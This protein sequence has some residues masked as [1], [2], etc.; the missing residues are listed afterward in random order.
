MEVSAKSG[1]GMEQLRVAILELAGAV[2]EGAAEA[3]VCN[4]RHEQ[5]LLRAQ[6]AMQQARDSV[7]LGLGAD[8]AAIDVEEALQAIGE[9]SGRSVS[10]EVLNTIFSRFC[11]GK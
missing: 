2:P 4:A 6:T 9:I 1:Q 8:L 3:L 7:E 10:E 11:L 5:A